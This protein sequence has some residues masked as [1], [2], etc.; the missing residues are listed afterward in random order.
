MDD[1]AKRQPAGA[2]EFEDRKD[3]KISKGIK[4][5]SHQSSAIHLDSL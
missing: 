3:A 1:S 5:R 2:L 4:D